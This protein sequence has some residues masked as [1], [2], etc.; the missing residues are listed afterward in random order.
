M[1]YVP[2]LAYSS[3]NTVE[4]TG[5]FHFACTSRTI[6]GVRPVVRMQIGYWTNG[7]SERD[8]Y[9]RFQTCGATCYLHQFYHKHLLPFRDSPCVEQGGGRGHGG[10]GTQR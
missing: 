7:L 2:R 6:A 10:G 1:L 5:A 4:R 8:P 3:P 9:M